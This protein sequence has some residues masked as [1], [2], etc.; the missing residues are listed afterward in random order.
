MLLRERSRSP[1]SI[2][3]SSPATQSSRNPW[4]SRSGSFSGA[5]LPARSADASGE[6]ATASADEPGW[7]VVGQSRPVGRHSP[8]LATDRI[9]GRDLVDVAAGDLADARHRILPCRD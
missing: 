8:A 9:E 4:P 7:G 3:P 2:T 1:D 6:G 5:S